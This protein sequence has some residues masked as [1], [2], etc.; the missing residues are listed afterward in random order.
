[1]I[2]SALYTLQ[3]PLRQA[4]GD[5]NYNME[6]EIAAFVN[7]LAAE[8]S[9]IAYLFFFVNSVLQAVF[10]PYPGDT[11]IV[12]LGYLSSRNILNTPVVLTTILSGTYIGSVLLYA[13]S[14][15]FK[16]RFINNKFIKR[17]INID[18]VQSLESWFKKYGAF[19]LIGSKFIPGAAFIAIISAGLFELSPISVFIS[20]G[21]STLI[22]NTALFLAGRLAG[23]NMEKMKLAMAEYT[24]FIIFGVLIISILY[25]YIKSVYKRK[26]KDK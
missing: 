2:K 24:H 6:K 19:V 8:N 15:K 14:Y 13:V 17:Y 18:K 9:V 16:S 1:M 21:L 26:F 12:L 3:N 25:L 20:L 23:N 4:E 5:R 7:T 11:I 22:H 10:P